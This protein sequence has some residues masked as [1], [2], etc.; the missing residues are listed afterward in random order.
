MDNLSPEHRRK[1]MQNIRSKGTKPELTIFQEFKKRKIYFAPH[2]DKI[3]G[4]PDLAFRRKKV[5]VFIDSDFW[6]G[7][8]D[9]YPP[10]KSNTEYWEAKIARNRQ[11]DIEVNAALKEAGWTVIR[12]WAYDIKHDLDS[13]LAIILSAIGRTDTKIL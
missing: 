4:K 8:P 13:S 3:T 10:P 11:R 12:I 5:A 1:N 7:H 6:H 9:R 2:A